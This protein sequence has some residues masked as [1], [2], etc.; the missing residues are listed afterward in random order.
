[1]IQTNETKNLITRPSGKYAT[2]TKLKVGG[3][4]LY[5]GL[6]KYRKILTING[7]DVVYIDD[8]GHLGQCS[9]QHFVSKCPYEATDDEVEFLDKIAKEK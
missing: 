1:M 3:V 8:W 5:K 2:A 9:K 4:Y 7:N 6:Y